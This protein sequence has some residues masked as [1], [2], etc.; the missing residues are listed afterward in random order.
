MAGFSIDSTSFNSTGFSTGFRILLPET[1]WLEPEHFEQARAISNNSINSNSASSESHQW[2]A[3]LNALAQQGLEQWLRE[4]MLEQVCYKEIIPTTYQSPEHQGPEHQSPEHQSPEHQSPE[5][6]S[7]EQFAAVSFV[8][9]DEFR[10]CLIAVEHLLDEVVELPQFTLGQAHFYVVL[11][12]SEEQEQVTLR[13]FLSYKQL[14]NHCSRVHLR[15]PSDL[16]QL[17]LSLFDIELNH[18]LFYCRFLEPIALPLPAAQAE[19]IGDII[20]ESLKTASVKLSQWLQGVF[21]EEW[22]AIDALFD[23]G[24]SLALSTRHL[25]ERQKRGKLINLGMQ[26]G[27]ETVALLVNVAE[28][29]EEKLGVLVQVHPINGKRYLP[30]NLKLTLLSKAGRTLQEITARGQ[31]NYIQLRQFKGEPGKRFSIQVSLRTI[32]VRE[33]FEL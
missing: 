30:P 13:G 4:R 12:I 5:H 9:V 19:P 6:Q 14:V 1:I 17:P 21:D 29:S 24:T 8:Q 26:L 10:L 20:F 15:S 23:P 16:Y 27:G 33:A 18:L 2:Q 28:E 22:Q 7:S 3:Y 32:S 25:L 31:D 11:E